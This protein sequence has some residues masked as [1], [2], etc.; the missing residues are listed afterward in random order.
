[1]HLLAREAGHLL[2]LVHHRVQRVRDDD[3]EGVG[4]LGLQVLP[5]V[6]DD[7]EVDRKQVVAR[8]A[9]LARHAR[10]DDDDVRAGDVVPARRAGDACVA[11]QHGAVLLEVE[12]LALREPDLLGDVEEHDVAELASCRQRG[13]L[14]TDVPSADQS[15]LVPAGHDEDSLK[16]SG[17]LGKERV[18]R[19]TGS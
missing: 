7:L 19:T 4:R 16:E 14:T 1:M 18:C 3:D 6:A 17:G 5:D 9:G 15:N 8:H 12:R 13:Q 10:G 11:A 2:Q